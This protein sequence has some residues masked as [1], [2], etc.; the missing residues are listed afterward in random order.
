MLPNHGSL[1]IIAILEEEAKVVTLVGDLKTPLSVISVN[2]QKHDVLAGVR[3]KCNICKTEPNKC[4][5]LKG[6]VQ[7]F[8][9]YG[10]LQFM[11]ARAVR[12]VSVIEPIE[13]VYRKTKIKAP[14]NKIQP[15]NIRVP[16]PFPYQ[17]SKAVPWKYDATISIGGKEIQFSDTEIINI[18]G[19]YGMTRSGRVFA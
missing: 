12:E 2:L 11:R 14:M 15:I 9:N 13:I 16:A 8:I 7:E 5:E 10:V 18:A 1:I 19:T 17:D 4:E 3:D 6:Y